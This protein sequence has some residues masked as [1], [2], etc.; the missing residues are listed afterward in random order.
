MKKIYL[1]DSSLIFQNAF[2]D[3][4]TGTLLSPIETQNYVIVQVAESYYNSSFRIDNHIQHCDLEL[5]F[6]LTD[7]LICSTNKISDNLKKHETY[8]SFKGDKHSLSSRQSCRFQTLAINFKNGPCFALFD[9]I[10]E[11]FSLERKVFLSDIASFLS[12]VIAEFVSPNAPF[13]LNNLDSLITGI[14]VC[15]ARFGETTERVN[16]L[17]TEEKLPIIIN[18]ID[19]HFLDI[20]SLSELSARFG[21]SYSHIC[22]VFKK[23]YGKSPNEYLLAKKLEYSIEL[24]KKDKSI[25]EISE[26]LGYS[27]PYNYSRAFKS[28]Y[29]ASPTNYI[30]SLR[31]K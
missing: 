15:L 18:Y 1:N 23:T 5:T 21:Y 17:S 7:S 3:I 24:L 11:N 16:V 2:F 30:K 12:S 13:F 25:N 19:S 22:K 27:T 6:P 8:I 29:K 28:I 20:K 14:L 26:T 10:K 9:K 4:S 31:Q